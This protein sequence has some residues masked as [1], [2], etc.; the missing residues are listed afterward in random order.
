MRKNQR[1]VEKARMEGK[2]DERFL[3]FISR[4]A[5]SPRLLTF[6]SVEDKSEK[7]VTA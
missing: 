7:C 6:I 1:E 5:F 2:Y 3:S 4:D